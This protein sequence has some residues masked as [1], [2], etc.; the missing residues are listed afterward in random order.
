MH[1]LT[2][3]ERNCSFSSKSCRACSVTNLETGHVLDSF[4]QAGLPD[5]SASTQHLHSMNRAVTTTSLF[6]WED[7][8]ATGLARCWTPS[9]F[10]DSV[11]HAQN[12][13]ISI[14]CF[15][16]EASCPM[17]SCMLWGAN[18]FGGNRH[19]STHLVLHSVSNKFRFSGVHVY[20]QLCF[21][22]CPHRLF[23]PFFW[24]FKLDLWIWLEPACCYRPVSESQP[25]QGLPTRQLHVPGEK[26]GQQVSCFCKK[27]C[28]STRCDNRHCL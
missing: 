3:V 10:C 5:I 23:L 22:R 16:W 14:E 13:E 9:M 11:Q 8:H 25:N 7:R 2:A 26:R 20:D 28:L 6:I 1:I 18:A 27:L 15:V 19:R 4:R 17:R 24:S 12:Q 21:V